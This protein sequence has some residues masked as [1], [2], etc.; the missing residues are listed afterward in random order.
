MIA[1]T[2]RFVKEVAAE[3]KKVSW[4]TREDLMSSAWIVIVSS[5]FLGIFIAAT[6][7]VIS[8]GIA[9]LIR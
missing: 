7:F 6:D 1:R 8:K 9:F 3:L 5:A 4:T 2:V